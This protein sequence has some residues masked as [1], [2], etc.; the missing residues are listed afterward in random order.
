M[1]GTFEREDHRGW[2]RPAAGLCSELA[3]MAG[4]V[5]RPCAEYEDEVGVYESH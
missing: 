2:T 1:V 3:L 4:V 5:N